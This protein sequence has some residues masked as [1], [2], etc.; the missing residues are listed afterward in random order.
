MNGDDIVTGVIH[1]ADVVGNS[2]F[3]NNLNG[4]LI[5]PFLHQTEH[6]IVAVQGLGDAVVPF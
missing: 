6:F 4:R 2:P 5:I 3:I 1:R